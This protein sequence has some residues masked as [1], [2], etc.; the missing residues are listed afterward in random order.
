MSGVFEELPLGLRELL[1][2]AMDR[3]RAAMFR[4]RGGGRAGA[5]TRIGLSF[6]CP[7]KLV[8]MFS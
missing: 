2:L 1:S 6:Q 4:L 8:R 3:S 7:V 5:K